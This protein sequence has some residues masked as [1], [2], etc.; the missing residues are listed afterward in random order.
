MIPW[1][2]QLSVGVAQLDEHHAQLVKIVNEIEYGVDGNG[3]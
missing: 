1:D 2:D 3:R